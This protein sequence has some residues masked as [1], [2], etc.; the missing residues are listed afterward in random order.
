[1]QSHL[2]KADE[3]AQKEDSQFWQSET[4]SLEQFRSDLRKFMARDM[5]LFY[6]YSG[7]VRRYR[8]ENQFFD[9][10]PEARDGQ[11]TVHY[12]PQ[13]GHTYWHERSRFRLL[14]A[15]CQWAA[16]AFPASS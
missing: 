8:Y 14:D 2:G 12:F 10:C 5:P 6:A 13:A 15:V 1:V 7:S 16:D 4:P 9:V 11:I 3:E